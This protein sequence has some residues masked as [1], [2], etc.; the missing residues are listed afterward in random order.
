M[1]LKE[2]IDD[3]GI[4][5]PISADLQAKL[6]PDGTNQRTAARSEVGLADNSQAGGARNESHFP[7]RSLHD[8]MRQTVEET[9]LPDRGS[10]RF[11]LSSK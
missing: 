2:T 10:H 6:R 7:G 9:V 3:A 8:D 11:R 1:S 5:F 4:A